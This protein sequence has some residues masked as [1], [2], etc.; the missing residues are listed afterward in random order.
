MEKAEN[1]YLTKQNTGRQM[2]QDMQV[3]LLRWICKGFMEYQGN[4]T[5][6]GTMRV[7]YC[8]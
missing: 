2:N 4:Q 7:T 8:L 5:K 6:F 3:W 1:K